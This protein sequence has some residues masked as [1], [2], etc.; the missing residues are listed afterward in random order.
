[1][2]SR[3]PQNNQ[4]GPGM[5]ALFSTCCGLGDSVRVFR[6]E[7]R[8]LEGDQLSCCALKRKPGL[9]NVWKGKVK[10]AEACPKE[11]RRT[12]I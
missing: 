1:M 2:Q 10:F 12:V 3:R 8:V 7:P 11:T 6:M 9:C 4:F 5:K